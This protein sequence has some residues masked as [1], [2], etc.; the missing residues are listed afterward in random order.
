MYNDF[1]DYNRK[2]SLHQHEEKLKNHQKCKQRNVEKI[3]GKLIEYLKN[4]K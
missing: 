2:I 4:K 1:K 3:K